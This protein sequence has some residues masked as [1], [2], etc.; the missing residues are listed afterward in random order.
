MATPTQLRNQIRGLT[1]LA[2]VDLNILLRR[3]LTESSLSA[4]LPPLVETYGAAAATVAAEW[5]DEFRA[6]HR[7]SGRFR[8]NPAAIPDSGEHAL[9]GW[10]FSE[11]TD[12]N[13][14]KVLIAGGVQRRIVNFSRL[15]VMG[16]SIEDPG[17]RGW[18]RVGAGEC[19]FCQLLIGRG[20]VYSEASADFESHDHCHCA[21]VPAF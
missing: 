20:A 8:A 1:N 14:L 5:Y 9:I 4:A 21:A 15:T 13:A 17:A 18:E 16:S 11:A 6:S 3:S 19:D 10:A 12:E 2:Q 7:P